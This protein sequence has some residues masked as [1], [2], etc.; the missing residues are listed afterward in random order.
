M[1]TIISNKKMI[2]IV[3]SVISV[4]IRTKMKTMTSNTVM[5]SIV[6]ITSSSETIVTMK[7]INSN[8]EM[9]TIVTTV[10]SSET[11]MTLKTI[12]SNREI[13]AGTSKA[14]VTILTMISYQTVDIR[15]SNID[16][17]ISRLR[18]EMIKRW[19][20]FYHFII[21]DRMMVYIN[22]FRQR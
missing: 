9:M 5:M 12:I 13:T 17:I 8:K 2:I 3:P 16:F 22:F 11:M 6:T 14:I 21:N 20:T 1:T 15:V 10:S 7:T 4:V 18:L 19:F